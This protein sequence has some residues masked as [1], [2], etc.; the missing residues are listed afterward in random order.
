MDTSSAAL[1]GPLEGPLEWDWSWP[2]LAHEL[3]EE[4]PNTNFLLPTASLEMPEAP[5]SRPPGAGAGAVELEV[6][7]PGRRRGVVEG[8]GAFDFVEGQSRAEDREGV[9]VC[10]ELFELLR[11]ALNRR[12]RGA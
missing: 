9:P 3:F 10:R 8:T 6:P 12:G 11:A 1:E 2:P 5:P 7:V 4:V